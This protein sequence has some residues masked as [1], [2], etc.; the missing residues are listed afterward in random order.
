[1]NADTLTASE[2]ATALD[3]FAASDLRAAKKFGTVIIGRTLRGTLTLTRQDSGAYRLAS[4]EGIIAEGKPAVV[5]PA[6]AA[7]YDVKVEAA[8]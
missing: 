4:V 3:K 2:L 1:M 7:C 6:L 8:S 5:R